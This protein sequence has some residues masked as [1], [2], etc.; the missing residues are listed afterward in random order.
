MANSLYQQVGF[1][2]F[3]GCRPASCSMPTS[4]FLQV[5]SRYRSSFVLSAPEPACGEPYT[6]RSLLTIWTS[7]VPHICLC[8]R[9]SLPCSISFT[10]SA[11]HHAANKAITAAPSESLSKRPFYSSL[12]SSASDNPKR[13][14]QTVNKLLHHKSSSPLSTNHFSWHFTCRQLSFFFSQAK[15]PNSVFLLPATL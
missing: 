9:R 6:L 8:L 10:A 2:G 4:S 11:Q 15:Y 14:W 1:N 3:R 12:V 5:F 13:L 7:I